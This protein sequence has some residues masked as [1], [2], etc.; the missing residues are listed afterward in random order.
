MT[1]LGMS[2]CLTLAARRPSSQ[3]LKSSHSS[4]CLLFHGGCSSRHTPLRDGDDGLGNFEGR[5]D[6][7]DTSLKLG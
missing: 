5:L 3:D 7:V 4:F 1:V 6:A 2:F